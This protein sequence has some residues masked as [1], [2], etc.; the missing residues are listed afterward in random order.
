MGVKLGLMLKRKTMIIIGRSANCY[1]LPTNFDCKNPNE[2]VAVVKRYE[3]V[4]ISQ[5]NFL[6][7]EKNSI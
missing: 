6:A 3:Y 4:I 7:N 1:T 2:R 5:T